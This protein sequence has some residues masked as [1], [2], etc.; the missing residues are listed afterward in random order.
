MS[1]LFRTVGLCALMSAAMVSVATADVQE[2][3]ATLNGMMLH[4]KVVLPK[5]FDPEKTYPAVLAFPPGGQDMDMVDATLEQNYRAQAEQRGYIV[6]EPAA[7]DGAFFFEAGAGVFPAFLT[8]LTTDYKILDDKFHAAG[9]S[10][11][12]LSAFLIASRYPQ[13][14]W[15]VTGFPGFL[16]DATQKQIGA[17]SRMCVHMFAGEL[18]TGWP[19][20]MRQQAALF[21]SFGFN[22]TLAVEK[23]Q[24]HVIQ[25]LTGPGAS[26]L[27]DQFDAAR[28]GQCAK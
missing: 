22:V 23:G 4:Y 15:S 24:P 26:R 17:L 25:T 7:P 2:K 13:Y 16:Q 9:N 21:R 18:D 5:D 28:K 8:K 3:T 6:V 11:G 12:G 20:E 1:R 14:F 19:D 27:F 10:N